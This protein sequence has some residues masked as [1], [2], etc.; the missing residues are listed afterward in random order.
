[1][2][3]W[4]C[5]P[6]VPATD[7]VLC[8]VLSGDFRS[9]SSP[10]GP[11]SDLNVAPASCEKHDREWELPDF[12]ESD[13]CVGYIL[14]WDA[15]VFF[16]LIINAILLTGILDFCIIPLFWKQNASR[17]DNVLQS[18]WWFTGPLLTEPKAIRTAGSTADD[19][20]SDLLIELK[21]Q[22]YKLVTL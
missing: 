7:C 6:A 8:V 10:Y 20:S 22:F 14:A 9:W 17:I 18:L 16:A 21:A 11:P 2:R 1:M 12:R 13:R 19:R 4:T 5:L 3:R 15:R